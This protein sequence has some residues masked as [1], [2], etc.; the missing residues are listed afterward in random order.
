ME[1][2]FEKVVPRWP[3]SVND[4]TVTAHYTQPRGAV[5]VNPRVQTVADSPNRNASIL[6]A[7]TPATPQSSAERTASAVGGSERQPKK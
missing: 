1:I 4:P 6:D 5:P 7:E 3:P 2:Q